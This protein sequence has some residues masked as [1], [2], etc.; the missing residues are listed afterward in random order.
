MTG[1]VRKLYICHYEKERGR[2]VYRK[3]FFF[4]PRYLLKGNVLY[5]QEWTWLPLAIWNDNDQLQTRKTRRVRNSLFL[6]LCPFILLCNL[7]W[8]SLS[9]KRERKR[10]NIVTMN[11]ILILNRVPSLRTIELYDFR[12]IEDTNQKVFFLL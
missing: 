9:L 11:V 4:L 5:I 1:T 6:Y 7:R 3:G 10:G 12:Q 8:S 2:S